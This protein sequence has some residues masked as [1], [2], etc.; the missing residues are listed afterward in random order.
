MKAIFGEFTLIPVFFAEELL[1]ND[2][3]GN[4]HNFKPCTS[5][6]LEIIMT[7]RKVSPFMCLEVGV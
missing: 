4:G 2:I 3:T 6:N 1:A 7:R 5:D